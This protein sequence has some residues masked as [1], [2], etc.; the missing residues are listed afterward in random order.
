MSKWVTFYN[1]MFCGMRD[2]TIHENKKVAT[3]Y[4]KKNYRN[5]FE[6]AQKIEVELPMSYG[7]PMRKFIGISL[8]TFKK[9]YGY[10]P[11]E[12]VSE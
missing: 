6:L 4:F 7:Y 12:E 2:I 3:K 10:D 9:R 11:T 8:P 5:Y 1:D